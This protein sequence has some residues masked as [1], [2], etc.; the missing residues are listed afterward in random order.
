ML[1]Q[2]HQYTLSPDLSQATEIRY[3]ESL[4]GIL[5][6]EKAAIGN[7]PLYRFKALDRRFQLLDGSRFF[8]VQKATAAVDRIS[9][10]AACPIA[11]NQP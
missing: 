11:A 1:Q 2:L 10:L 5:I 8:A 3:A 9:R 7:G 4:I 6:T